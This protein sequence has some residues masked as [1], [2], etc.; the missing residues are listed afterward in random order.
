AGLDRV[1]DRDEHAARHAAYPQG[2]A[3]RHGAAA[4]RGRGMHADGGFLHADALLH[5]SAARAREP[6]DPRQPEW[7]S[8]PAGSPGLGTP[9]IRGNRAPSVVPLFSEAAP[10]HTGPAHNAGRAAL[11]HH[12]WRQSAAAR[13]KGRFTHT[14]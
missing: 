6:D 13:S 3:P 11:R 2:A 7:E 14:G 4:L 10:R 9:T 8:E 12:E 1:P 5:E